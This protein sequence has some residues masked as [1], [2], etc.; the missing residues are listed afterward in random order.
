MA[1]LRPL[2]FPSPLVKPD[3]RFSRIRL[4]DRLHCPAHGD[5]NGRL[6]RA[7]QLPR[8]SSDPCGVVRLFAN[9]RPS[10]P[11]K[12]RLK[13]GSF[14]PPALP[15]FNSTMTL[16]D[17]HRV[18]IAASMELTLHPNGSPTL[19]ASP[20][21]R[22][23]PTTPADRMEAVDTFCHPYCLPRSWRVGIR[24]CTFEACSGFTRVM[25]HRIARP[26]KAA[27]VTRLRHRQ[28]SGDAARQLPVLST[29][30]RGEP[31]STGHACPRGTPGCARSNEAKSPRTAV[32]PC[33]GL[34]GACCTSGRRRSSGR[35]RRAPA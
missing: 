35:R 23:M 16:S 6:R 13:Q 34:P 1:T 19:P 31:S 14:P 28:F 12:A 7:V 25:A 3:V 29:S 2:R 17:S 26:P 21:R 9:H 20:L 33:G 11:S 8:K 24:N 10:T 27:F 5:T 22:A 30:L 15:G 4:S 32:R 18:R